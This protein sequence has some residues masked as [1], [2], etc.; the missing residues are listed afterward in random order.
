MALARAQQQVGALATALRENDVETIFIIHPVAGRM[1]G[2]MNVLLAEADV[3]HTLVKEMDDVKDQMST[4]DVTF[5]IGSNDIVNSAAE[6]VAGCS[7]WGMPVVRVW[8]S[9]KV[10]FMKRSMGGGYADLENPVFYKE[11]TAMLL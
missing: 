4:Y 1:P 7:I 9:T 5:C 11:N 3:P 6:E 10:I 8:E 2:Q